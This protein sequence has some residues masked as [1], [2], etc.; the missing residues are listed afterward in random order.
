MNKCIHKM[1]KITPIKS[2]DRFSL[3]CFMK[4]K[5]SLKDDNI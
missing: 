3:R 1:V 2:K 4:I 5:N